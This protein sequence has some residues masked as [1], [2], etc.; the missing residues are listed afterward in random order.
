[1][2]ATVPGADSQSFAMSYHWDPEKVSSVQKEGLGP[3]FAVFLELLLH[4]FIR[5]LI[6]PCFKYLFAI[7]S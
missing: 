2:L 7:F 5:K 1:M 6:S 3:S 4:I